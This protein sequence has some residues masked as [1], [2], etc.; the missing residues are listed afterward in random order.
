LLSIIGLMRGRDATRPTPAR[1]WRTVTVD[2]VIP[3]YNE[4]DN[5]I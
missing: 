2:V 3:A 4:Q 5:I 1:D